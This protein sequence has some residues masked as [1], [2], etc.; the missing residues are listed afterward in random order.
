[1]PFILSVCLSIFWRKSVSIYVHMQNSRFN[2]L[3]VSEMCTRRVKLPCQ[4]Y[5][6]DKTGTTVRLFPIGKSCLYYRLYLVYWPLCYFSFLFENRSCNAM[7]EEIFNKSPR[8]RIRYMQ[9][10]SYILDTSP[11][12][13]ERL[14]LFLF[15]I[16]LIA[17]LSL[18]S[19]YVATF[20]GV[21]T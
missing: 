15:F 10:E 13:T 3:F 17:C 4:M 9:N 19:F 7:R 11:I 21:A 1:M 14:G 5:W 8:K 20:L 18:H 6:H 2:F 16:H 12:S